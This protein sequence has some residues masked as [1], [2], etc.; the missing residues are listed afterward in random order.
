MNSRTAAREIVVLALPQLPK[1]EDLE[2]VVE[3][4]ETDVRFRM[5][6]AQTSSFALLPILIQSRFQ[7]LAQERLAPPKPQRYFAEQ[8]YYFIMPEPEFHFP[9]AF[10]RSP[11]PPRP[12]QS[13]AST[14]APSVTKERPNHTKPPRREE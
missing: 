14:I 6:E 13:G 9:G 5:G 7:F 10:R 12:P 1:D 2:T 11:F 8:R 3:K 4:V